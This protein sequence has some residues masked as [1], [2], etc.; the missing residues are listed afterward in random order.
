MVSLHNKRKTFNQDYY[1][2]LMVNLNER[3]LPAPPSSSSALA[4]ATSN[5]TQANQLTIMDYSDVDDEAVLLYDYNLT[6]M[7]NNN[8]Y[9]NNNN[10]GNNSS[11]GSNS[12]NNSN[13]NNNINTNLSNLMENFSHNLFELQPF[14]ASSSSSSNN[15]N[16]NMENVLN[17]TS[18]TT[19]I[20]FDGSGSTSSTFSPS[21]LLGDATTA[22]VTAA[23]NNRGFL[24]DTL[25]GSVMTTATATVTA[26]PPPPS[27]PSFSPSSSLLSYSYSPS[28]VSS[29]AAAASAAFYETTVKTTTTTTTTNLNESS[30]SS[31]YWE[32]ETA[33]MDFLYRHSL[34][35]TIV[36]CIAYVIVFLVGLV[37]NSFV[38]A[39]VLR[40]RNMRTVTNY[41]IVNLAIADILVIVFCLPATLMSNI[42]VPWMLG[43]LMCK[44]VPYIQGV[45]VAASVY[46]LI[47]VSLDR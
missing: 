30:S 9:N 12:N 10:H 15:N 39:V 4:V 41:F 22:A 45:S 6:K 46:S 5:E 24:M 16:L 18:D 43:W 2:P 37:G 1:D 29:A 35:M 42:F 3:R 34:A 32:L 8:N 14:L 19:N 33:D 47:A 11:N 25:M 21:N 38:I 40:M 13:N 27:F 26:A 36:Y 20:S 23:S 17:S 28:S 31:S 7:S 44:T